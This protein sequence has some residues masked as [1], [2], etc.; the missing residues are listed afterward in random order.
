MRRKTDLNKIEN[1]LFRVRTIV[2][3][4]EVK[5]DWVT[6]ERRRRKKRKGTGA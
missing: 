5:N 4:L 2:G 6:D 1:M 3:R